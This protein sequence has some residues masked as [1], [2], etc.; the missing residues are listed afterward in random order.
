[1]G[2]AYAGDFIA[3]RP[4]GPKGDLKC[5]GFRSSDGTVFQCY[6][7]D[8]IKIAKL[9]KKIDD[10][11]NGAK[12][13]WQALMR[14]WKFV[15]NEV[16]GLPA[17]A[18]RKLAE[19]NDCHPDVEV[20]ALGASQMRETVMG[21][22]LHQLEELFGSVPSNRTLEC[23]GFAEL[24]PALVAIAR[25]DP[26]PTPPITAPSPL[27]I[28]RNS[29]SQDAAGLLQHG[30]RREK[31]VQDFFRNW[32]DPSLGESI[33]ETFRQ[34]YARLQMMPLRPDQVFRQL[35]TFAGGLGG[36]P[37]H[38]GAVLAVLS[39]FFERC[40]IFEDDRR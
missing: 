15:H 10:D 21:L 7:P 38:Q 32:P 19:L 39:Y 27:K 14:R 18:V 6:A 3:V 30:R 25:K 5:D 36:E 29:L 12:T 2:H 8:N 4:Y 31:L 20:A 28:Q 11:F 34:E 26:D 1:M 16:H 23:L 22:S 9:L 33:A 13:H 17:E 24:Q 37:S 35:Q 40:D